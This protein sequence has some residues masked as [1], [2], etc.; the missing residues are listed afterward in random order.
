MD[1]ERLKKIK[2][3]A[4]SNDDIN[5]IL[6]PDTKI[7]TYPKFCEMESID[8]AFD[9]LGRCIFLFLTESETSG[10]WL[11]MYKKDNIIYYFDPYGEKPEA[12]REHITEEQLMALGQGEPCLMNLLKQSGYKVF[13]NAVQYQKETPGTNTCGKHCVL[14]LVCKDMTDKQYFN[15]FKEEMKKTGAKTPDDFVAMMIYEL[16]GK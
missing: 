7:F 5:T 2:E 12:L 11:A 15:M 14:R 13:S 6:D 9:S 1:S 8:D 4:L 3:Y 16:L 10:H